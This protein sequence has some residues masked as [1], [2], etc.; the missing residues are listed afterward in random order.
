MK[1]LARFLDITR[2][3]ALGC[4]AI[5]DVLVAS[6]GLDAESGLV[7][8]RKLKQIF[9]MLAR[10]AMKSHRAAETRSG[11]RAAADYEHRFTEHEYEEDLEPDHARSQPIATNLDECSFAGQGVISVVPA[12][13]QSCPC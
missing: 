2:G 6:A 13:K 10:R 11:C 1:D 8:K 7:L 4:A 5:Q 9:S 12:V 3:A